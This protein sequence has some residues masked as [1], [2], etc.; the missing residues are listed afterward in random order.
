MRTEERTRSGSP[1]HPSDPLITRSDI[2]EQFIDLL[3]AVIIVTSPEFAK[4]GSSQVCKL[5]VNIKID[6][7]S[8]FNLCV[9]SHAVMSARF[10]GPS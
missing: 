3:I 8:Y 2:L 1:H 6:E 5:G 7:D 9:F 4:N 10:D